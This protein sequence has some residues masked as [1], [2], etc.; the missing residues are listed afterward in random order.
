MLLRPTARLLQATPIPPF[1]P[2]GL[3]GLLSHP[4]P[5]P[6]L[7]AVYNATLTL[8]NTLPPTSV[9]RISTINLTNARLNTVAS[10]IPPAI[11]AYNATHIDPI[12]PALESSAEAAGW[13]KSKLHAAIAAAQ[14]RAAFESLRS[15][16]PENPEGADLDA[17]SWLEKTLR[18]EERNLGEALDVTALPNSPEATPTSD[19][20]VKIPK[21][22]VEPA[23]TAEQVSE[24]E[25]KLDAGLIEE[26][27][28]QSMAEMN[29]VKEMI[30]DKPW[31]PLQEPPIE[32]QWEYFERKAGAVPAS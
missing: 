3:T 2:T 16:V 17:Q 21:L 5:R 24:L 26:V 11:Q 13:P 22:P 20:T 1:S 9:Y 23:L 28:N 18:D 19:A 32:G 4:C 10:F 25:Q 29:L 8:L 15:T 6:T 31:E 7:I 30:K 14:I 27:V 12:L